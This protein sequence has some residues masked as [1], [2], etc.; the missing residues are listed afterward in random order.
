MGRRTR[1]NVMRPCLLSLL[2]L[3]LSG[4]LGFAQ[5]E[6]APEFPQPGSDVPGPFYAY[7][8]TGKKKGKFHC[9]VTEHELNPVAMVI[10]RGTDMTEGLKYLLVK[11]NNAVD[12]NPNTRLASFAV[13]TTDKLKDLAREDDA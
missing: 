4:S 8:A 2:A 9:L 6:K 5:T 10:V 1:E 11:L 13:F 7:M 3:S 12:R